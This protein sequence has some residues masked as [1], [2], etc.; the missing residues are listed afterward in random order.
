MRSGGADALAAAAGADELEERVR[1]S[2]DPRWTV[3]VAREQ[4]LRRLLTDSGRAMPQHAVSRS[5]EELCKMWSSHSSDAV[6]ALAPRRRQPIRRSI[7]PHKSTES[8][9]YIGGGILGTLLVVLLIVYVA[10]RV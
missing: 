4:A 10:R 5:P 3:A 6:G 1:S 2:A 9:M 7:P 8:Q